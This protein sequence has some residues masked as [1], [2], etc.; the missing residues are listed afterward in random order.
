MKY[1][2]DS[3]VKFK[4]ALKH[5][6]Y[7]HAFYTLEY[8]ERFIIVSSVYLLLYSYAPFTMAFIVLICNCLLH[9]WFFFLFGVT[10]S[11]LFYTVLYILYIC[12]CIYLI[13][14]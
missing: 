11:F 3:P 8:Y 4:T 12:N 1:I 5:F 10:L 6:L 2:S 7:S 9:L 14:T 13:L